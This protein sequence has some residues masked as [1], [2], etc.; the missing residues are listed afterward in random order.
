MDDLSDDE[1]EFDQV[2]K[3]RGSETQIMKGK[4][5]NDEDDDDNMDFGL[6]QRDEEPEETPSFYIKRASNPDFSNMYEEKRRSSRMQREV[7]VYN[8]DDSVLKKKVVEL[9]ISARGNRLLVDISATGSN[10]GGSPKNYKNVTCY[11][12]QDTHEDISR[13]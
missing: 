13:N 5:N 4:N 6:I 3:V 1:D 11:Q 12:L 9:D 2:E 7:S 8:Q 10:E